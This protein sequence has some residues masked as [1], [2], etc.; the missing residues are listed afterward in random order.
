MGLAACALLAST[1]RADDPRVALYYGPDGPFRELLSAELGLVGFELR[2][3]PL[4]A[5]IDEGEAL[6]LFDETDA[7]A[8]LDHHRGSVSLWVRTDGRAQRAAIA[9][10][11]D[12]GI[13]PLVIAETLRAALPIRSSVPAAMAAP[14][15]TPPPPRIATER[16]P[17]SAEEPPES[18]ERPM[19]RLELA[20]GPTL[21]Y[22]GRWS[23]GV[24]LEAMV[25]LHPALSAGAFA[26][27]TGSPAAAAVLRVDGRIGRIRLS[28]DAG[29][30][31]WWRE[32]PTNDGSVVLRASPGWTA[33]LGSALALDERWSI[34]GRIGLL[35]AGP[36]HRVGDQEAAL[37]L[38]VGLGAR[39]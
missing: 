4:P 11:D 2:S 17:P 31:V 24:S 13:A 29:P 8:V 12:P 9:V 32:R 35:R 16:A 28:I 1:A 34:V 33:G 10:S 14:E 7:A 21:L 39:F 27:L 3:G 18:A 6:A 5:P 22:G 15:W 37:T 20:A 36:R 23:G 30:A 19:P 26:L 25:R 38:S